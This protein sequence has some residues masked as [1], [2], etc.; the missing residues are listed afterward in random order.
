MI[1]GVGHRSV[2]IVK[3]VSSQLSMFFLRVHHMI[4]RD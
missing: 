4:S 3:L 2:L 1:M